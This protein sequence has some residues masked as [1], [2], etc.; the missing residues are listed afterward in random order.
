M[1]ELLKNKKIQDVFAII[2]ILFSFGLIYICVK[3]NNYIW[4]STVDWYNQH[5]VFPD[6]FRKLF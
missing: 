3:N 5:Y 1:Q 4:G 2:L 6:Y